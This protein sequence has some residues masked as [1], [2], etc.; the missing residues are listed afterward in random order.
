MDDTTNTK[1]VFEIY[2]LRYATSQNRKRY[3]NCNF[4]EN[5]DIHESKMPMDFFV[6]VI[7][8]E[9]HVILVDT[10]SRDWKC[11]DRGHQFI[12][13]PIESLSALNIK[14]EDVDDVVITHMHWGSRGQYRQAT[15][16]TDPHPAR[17]N[18]KR[19]LG[20]IWRSRR[21][22]TSFSWMMS[23]P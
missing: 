9:E 15:S 14:P 20:Q 13:C 10:G 18:E 17:R 2:A 22:I 7:K 19:G 6:W 3:H 12:R 16:C 23:A 11:N 21:S 8:N 1:P 5:P 4:C